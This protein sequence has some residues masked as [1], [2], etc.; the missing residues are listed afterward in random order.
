MAEWRHLIVLLP[1]AAGACVP[2]RQPD[3]A[4]GGPTL[5]RAAALVHEGCYPCLT[6][7]LDVYEERVA[8]SGARQRRAAATGGVDAALLLAL[9]QKELG[10]D[11]SDALRRA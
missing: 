8:S 2:H 4:P 5:D 11:L 3:T 10:L 1:L 9:R 6:G 7:A